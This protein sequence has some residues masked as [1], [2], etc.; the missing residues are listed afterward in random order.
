MTINKVDLE[1]SLVAQEL[2]DKIFRVDPHELDCQFLSGSERSEEYITKLADAVIN[3]DAFT[4][5]LIDKRNRV[6]AGHGLVDAAIRIGLEDIPAIRI[7]GLSAEEWGIYANSMAHFF[8]L[9]ELSFETFRAEA[10]KI[11]ELKAVYDAA[12][13]TNDGAEDMTA[14]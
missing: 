8:S 11:I 13:D 9:D 10:Q 7:E 4:P 12:N 1:T 5:V 3:I 6:I 2:W 14:P